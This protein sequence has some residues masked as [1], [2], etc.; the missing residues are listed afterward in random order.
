MGVKSLVFLGLVISALFIY[1]CIDSKKDAFY[2]SMNQEVPKVVA[3]TVKEELA[4]APVAVATKDPSFAYVTGVKSKVAALL[5]TKDKNGT[6]TTM[7]D[8]ICGEN[9]CVKDIKYFEDT[10][11]FIPSSQVLDLI[12]FSIEK[13]VDNFAIYIDQNIVKVDG[14]LKEA[15]NKEE[16]DSK[17]QYFID[18]KYDVTNNTHI[19]EEKPKVIPKEEHSV[20]E[21]LQES[22]PVKEVIENK[23]KIVTK[24]QNTTVAPIKEEVKEVI[25]QEIIEK[26]PKK[27]EPKPVKEVIENRSEIIKEVK[28]VEKV[29][30]VKSKVVQPIKKP[31]KV[32]KK[33]EP[34]KK[35]VIEDVSV[36][37][38]FVIPEHV[39][40]QEA[41]YRI[42]DL[43]I[44]EPIS[45]E[46]DGQVT[47][48]SQNTLNKIADILLGQDGVSITVSGH[49]DSAGDPTYSKVVSQKRADSVRNYLVKS[50]LRRSIIKSVGYG[51][52]TQSGDPSYTSIEINIK[53]GR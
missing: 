33:V 21:A 30:V 9:G 47:Q 17:L 52:G 1:L 38:V 11:E 28:K 42:G 23:S 4:P 24:E 51:D 25:P 40:V 27:E 31:K 45:F 12:N 8:D 34:I 37:D 19:K 50:G 6:I 26:A 41:S 20:V 49:T 44:V 7:I 5:S 18:N 22:K 14:E 32:V 39:G 29:E 16:I 10:K 15:S 43:L 48:D 3:P 35:K 2:A 36:D 53:E 13:N 46:E